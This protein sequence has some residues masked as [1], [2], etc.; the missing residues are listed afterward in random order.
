MRRSEVAVVRAIDEAADAVERDLRRAWITLLSFVVLACTLVVGSCRAD[1]PLPRGPV[2]SASPATVEDSADTT[3]SLI[4]GLA[5]TEIQMSES[6]GELPAG[7]L[8]SFTDASGLWSFE[9]AGP[10]ERLVEGSDIDRIRIAP[11]GRRILYFQ[12]PSDAWKPIQDWHVY[13][14]E[15]AISEALPLPEVLEPD[16]DI[17]ADY[18]AE[19][20][21][22]YVEQ[23]E[24]TPRLD[25][26]L[27]AVWMAFRTSDSAKPPE[28]PGWSHRQDDLWLIDLVE[29]T[30]TV[31]LPPG[32]GGHFSYSPDGSKIALASTEYSA[33]SSTVAVANFDGSERRTLLEHMHLNSG[34][35]YS[36]FADPKW[37]ADGSAILVTAYDESAADPPFPVAWHLTDAP[38]VYELDLNGS[39]VKNAELPAQSI[40]PSM[41][42]GPL[43][44]ADTS[45]LAI[46]AP[47]P[48]PTPI[49]T[50][51]PHAYPPP[52]DST[53]YPPEGW[54]RELIVF[55]SDGTSRTVVATNAQPAVHS[56]SPDGEAIVYSLQLE[57]EGR[58]QHVLDG[59]ELWTL[60][61][62]LDPIGWASDDVL[63]FRRHAMSERYPGRIGGLAVWRRGGTHVRMIATAS[64]T[65][66]PADG[67]IG[68]GNV[69]IL[70][71]P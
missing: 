4:D 54:P 31:I 13:H 15:A 47:V 67:A 52:V 63:V 51:D 2:E 9:G 23:L 60:P 12:G 29:R 36:P 45:R 18:G 35:D 20:V 68:V 41:P 61:E 33:G 57:T 37:K 24:W 43:W 27:G 55:T 42:Y 50:A 11:D 5:G 69:D 56:L 62:G 8:V 64:R 66:D 59:D 7:A 34:T 14:R 46:V 71:A 40:R 48:T 26:E 49:A 65:D 3:S 21:T 53:F 58:R 25:P 38:V 32:Q 10:S 39:V 19:W 6:G 44:A 28:G 70:A 22:R 17:V 1:S 30:S 16:P